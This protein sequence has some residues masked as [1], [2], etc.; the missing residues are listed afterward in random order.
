MDSKTLLL[1][2]LA[3][4]GDPDRAAALFAEDGVLELPFLRSL[5]V[6]PR[7]TGRSEIAGCLRQL[8]KLYPDVAFAPGD[9][10]VLIETPDK[11]FAEYVTHTTASATGRL[12]H[13][14]F[15]GYLVAEAGEI[16]LLRESFNP[17]A[18][19]QAQLPTGAAAIG[20]PGAE[21]HAF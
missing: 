20:A 13:Q 16:K 4:I 3:S 9:T 15:T 19:A 21:V 7:Y 11:T 5:G 8:R 14:L 10:T 18:M 1:K 6:Q 12:L 17:L 2:Y